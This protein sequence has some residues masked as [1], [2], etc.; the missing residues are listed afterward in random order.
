MISQPLDRRPLRIV[1]G[2]VTYPPDVN[3]AANFGHR[4]ATG[5]A[6]RGHDV[7]VICHSTDRCSGT[8]V[9]EGVTVH[10]VGSYATPVHPTIRVC[11]PWRAS[12]A[13]KRLL[14]EIR[15]DVVHVQSH[16]FIGRGIINAARRRGN[17][18]VATN[19]FMPENIFGYIRV[20]R[21]LQ[22]AASRLLWRNLVKHYSKAQV[23]TAPTPRAVQLLRDNGFANTAMPVSCGIDVDR[24][25]RRA[26]AFR[27]SNPDPETRTV[28][29]VGRL[30]E[31]KHIEDLLRAMSLL[32][33]H[34]PTRLEIVGD[35][36]KREHYEQLAADLGIAERVRFTGFV[37]DEELLDAYARA[38]LFCMPSVAE[39]QSLA[40][41]EAMSA[42]TPV[43]LANAMALPHLVRQGRNGWLHPPRDVQSLATAI[44]RIISDRSV[45][46]RM[47]AAS[48]ELVSQHDIDAILERFEQLYGHAIDA[49]EQAPEPAEVHTG[50]AS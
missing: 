17:G 8:T 26:A 15:P 47:G 9:E 34:V 20:P 46:D 2:A 36:S 35:G 24:Y 16:F 38:D 25:R 23:V 18:L 33:T 6:R 1:I 19:H 31:E 5:L 41:M 30:D 42:G 3:G 12:T 27:S 43:V 39:L 13:A 45:I 50:L 10:R 44:D 37:D 48:Q 7:H 49:G 4:L 14:D 21:M 32:H 40:T 29:F 11:T 22:T 28:L